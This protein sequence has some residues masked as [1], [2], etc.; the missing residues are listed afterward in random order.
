MA[1]DS[2]SLI[3]LMIS[4]SLMFSLLMTSSK[5]N[6]PLDDNESFRRRFHLDLSIKRERRG[7]RLVYLRHAHNTRFSTMSL[8]VVVVVGVPL[9]L[10]KPWPETDPSSHFGPWTHKALTLTMLSPLTI[11][12]SLH[13]H[14]I[15]VINALS[16]C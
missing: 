16:S 10:S 11:F 5:W 13:Q 1:K 9:S 8:Y 6:F 12:I 14:L 2:H 7:E 3:L 4:L 15:F